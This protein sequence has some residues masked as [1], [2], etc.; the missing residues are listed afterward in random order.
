M[1]RV[2]PFLCCTPT[3]KFEIPTGKHQVSI[4]IV[5]RSVVSVPV[6][7]CVVRGKDRAGPTAEVPRVFENREV[8]LAGEVLDLVYPWF[9]LSIDEDR[10]GVV[11]W[12]EI[13]D[14][15]KLGCT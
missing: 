6:Y 15:G 11:C 8:C 7:H 2:A 10:D 5:R 3:P 14:D 12:G 9:E 4:L 13:H 1:Q